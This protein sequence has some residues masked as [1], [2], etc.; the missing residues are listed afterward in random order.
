MSVEFSYFN[1]HS[2]TGKGSNLRMLDCTIKVKDLINTALEL[3]YKG[4]AITDHSSLSAHIEAIQY[5][6]EL[7]KQG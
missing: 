1:C 4:L 6:K 3:G 2:H 7:K 5:V